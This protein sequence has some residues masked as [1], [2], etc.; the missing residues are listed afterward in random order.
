MEPQID[1][2]T[3]VNP[4]INLEPVSAGVRFANYIVDIIAFYA[5]IFLAGVAFASFAPTEDVLA[6]SWFL[7]LLVFFG[8]Y[9]VM[10]GA[11]DGRTFGKMVTGTKAIREDGNPLTWKDALMRTL[12]R[13]IPFEPFSAFGGHPWHDR[14]SQTLVV[15]N[16]KTY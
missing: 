12:L 6:F 16:R 8:Y 13:M 3:D 1:L 11:L 4:D 14:W 2:L 10:E 9:T 15:K 5:L 7:T